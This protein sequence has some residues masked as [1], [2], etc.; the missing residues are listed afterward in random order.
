V[1]LRTNDIWSKTIGF[2][3]YAASNESKEDERVAQEH[4]AGLMMLLK[5]SN[6]SGSD[7]RGACKKCGQLGHLTFQCRNTLGAAKKQ[8][9]RRS[10]IGVGTYMK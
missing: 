6:L 1:A 5:M 8:V 7:T 4:S 2:D 10:G 3:P 9:R